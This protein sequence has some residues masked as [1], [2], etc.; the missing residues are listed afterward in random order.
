MKVT[1]E[2]YGATKDL[3]KNNFLE[4]EVKKN[5]S[6][7]DIKINL[8]KDYLGRATFVY[9]NNNE[10]GSVVICKNQTCSEKLKSFDQVKNFL[11]NN[12]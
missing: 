2:L 5:S 3:S 1:V 12:I 8:Q 6:I 11:E 10:E 9:K 7:K 4:L